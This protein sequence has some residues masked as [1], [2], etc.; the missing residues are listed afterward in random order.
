[1]QKIYNNMAVISD[2]HSGCQTALCPPRIRLDEGGFYKLNRI[3]RAV[4]KYWLEY[5]DWLDTIK[6][7]EPFVL[8]L[9]GDALDGSH[10]NNVATIS[11]NLSTQRK[12]A[13]ELL[14]PYADKAAEYYHIRGTEAHAGQSA[15]Q[16][17]MLAESLGA[18]P[19]RDGRYARWE[20][21]ITVGKKS[22][23]RCNIMHHIGTTGSQAY[24]ST[25]VMGELVDSFAE[26]GR[27][28]DTA[29]DYIIRSHR[30]R[31]IQVLIASE[32]GRIVSC[33][34]PAWQGKTPYV[35]RLKGARQSLPQ[36]GGILVR[37]APDGVNYL[38][39]F[40]RSPRR[41]K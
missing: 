3:Q 4:Y 5:W 41:E 1:M 34:T 37:E 2:L 40:V 6:K 16:E 35:W 30:H 20:L 21:N 23:K 38:T 28:D 25:A 18:I 8:V 7:K 15:E 11:N 9:N 29:P 33:T 22:K 27:T 26:A 17:E 36:W 14:K 39:E 31:Y 10:H 13:Y 32:K 24:E 19:D 12:I